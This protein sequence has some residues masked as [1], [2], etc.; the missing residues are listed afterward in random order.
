MRH[1]ARMR[2]TYAQARDR[3][4]CKVI[5]FG[6]DTNAAGT[7]MSFLGAQGFKSQIRTPEF[8]RRAANEAPGLPRSLE[9]GTALWDAGDIVVPSNN[10]REQ[11]DAVK[12][13]YLSIW[14]EGQVPFCIGGDHLIK[15]G[16]LEALQEFHSDSIVLYVDA[17]PDI[18]LSPAYDYST[19][20]HQALLRQPQFREAL[21]LVG[22]RQVN[23][24]EAE[25]IRHWKPQILWAQDFHVQTMNEIYAPIAALKSRYKKVFLS[26]D[27]DGL[28]PSCAP[29]VEAATP[30][31]P[32]LG[33]MLELIHRMSKDFDLIGLDVSEFIPD[34]DANKLTALTCAQILM[35]AYSCANKF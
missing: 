8:I 27:L 29:A 30:G 5:V 18:V 33:H 22:I 3:R 7:S 2:F 32:Q 20:I 24:A 9:L 4:D 10:V 26:I 35:E 23:E 15:H 25:G 11:I 12:S 21:F 19:V 17:H 16:A 1:I 28:D 6:A 14:R 13:Q 34:L 31:G